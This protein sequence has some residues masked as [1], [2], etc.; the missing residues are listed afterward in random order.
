MIHTERLRRTYGE[1]IALEALDLHVEPGEILGLLGPNGAG[2]STTVRILTGLIQPTSG[3]ASVAG[4]D[5]VTQ[6]LEAKQRLGY[7]PEQPVLYDVLTAAEFL[8]VISSL[9]HLDP[10][11]ARTRRDELLELLGLGDA[12]DQRLGTF[13]KGMKQKVV[14]AAALIHRPEVLILDEPLD[15]LD[16]NSARVVKELLR[17]L[18]AQGRTVLFCSHILEVVER[19]CTRIVVIANGRQIASGAPDDIAQ[20]TGTT[21]LDDAFAKL[22]GVRDAG[23]VSG[24]ILRALDR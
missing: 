3:R 16:A 22:T 21:S 4:F 17:S 1:K 6:P 9:H 12:R 15:G 23:Q 8:E 7:V 11:T 5:I 10:A 18:A 20:A 19:I 2:K 24:D 14:L 13:S